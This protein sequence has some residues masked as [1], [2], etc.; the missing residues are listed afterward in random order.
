M[1]HIPL[2]KTL[3]E[4]HRIFAQ[5]DGTLMK[6]LEE[7]KTAYSDSISQNIL[8]FV[9]GNLEDIVSCDLEGL[10]RLQQEYVKRVFDLNISS[11]ASY[12]KSFHQIHEALKTAFVVAYESF[13]ST[14]K[15]SW[16]SYQYLKELNQT[17][18]PYCNA[19]FIQTVQATKVLKGAASRAM[20]DLDHFLPKSIFPIFAITLSNLIPSCMY[21][22]QRFKGD[23]YTNFQNYF[24]PFDEE[25]QN[26]MTFKFC[27]T[28]DDYESVFS[29]LEP[30]CDEGLSEEEQYY[31]EILSINILDKKVF[32]KHKEIYESFQEK[33]ETLNREVVQL[34][35][36][37]N[38]QPELI[39]LLNQIVLKAKDYED[40]F[41]Q[42]MTIEHSVKP[43][44]Y[45][46]S[47]AGELAE[48]CG[49]FIEL[50]KEYESFPSIKKH[51]QVRKAVTAIK[52]EL[53]KHEKILKANFHIIEVSETRFK[54][55]NFVDAALGNSTDYQIEIMANSDDMDVKRRV[56]HNAALF[57][58]EA[59]YRSFRPY[60]NRK[61]RQSHIVNDLYKE[62]LVQQFPSLLTE[63]YMNTMVDV[64]II[65]EASQRHEVLGKLT[66]DVIL[67]VIQSRT[68]LSLTGISD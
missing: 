55:T 23:H 54:D 3:L 13:T 64:M 37:A 49:Q 4:K 62:Q 43:F 44:N 40:V 61:I 2:N 28:E 12:I 24:S 47:L 67:P 19:N 10:K 56:Y 20:A 51:R 31:L 53:E 46:E 45:F 17:V 8:D 66:Y 63:Q 68:N 27:Y 58:L 32:D 57:Q 50:R 48:I 59:V 25:M 42:F 35:Q 34:P 15:D 26:S 16:N 18:C 33:M 22:N 5:A 1:I 41:Y 6:K 9:I 7:L 14:G 52:D 30:L 60:I 29:K 11:N 21:C 36:H 39:E 38:C 65:D